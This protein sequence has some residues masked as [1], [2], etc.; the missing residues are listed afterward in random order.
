MGRTSGVEA[1]WG[2][3]VRKGAVV[4]LVA[5][6]L[7]PATSATAEAAP[8]YTY[9]DLGVPSG[10]GNGFLQIDANETG[11]IVGW[12]GW[13]YAAP[14]M[15]QLPTLTGQVITG[16]R[17]LTLV[18]DVNNTWMAVGQSPAA[19][20]SIHAVAWSQGGITDLGTLGTYAYYT[21]APPPGV[22]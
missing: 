16:E 20:G 17:N 18:N 5:A 13:I 19:D 8:A 11:V 3:A 21:D 22:S 15:Q 10:Y 12:D 6:G 9:T 1:R 7:L 14:A 2:R 4:A